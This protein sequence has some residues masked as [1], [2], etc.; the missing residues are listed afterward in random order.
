MESHVFMR[1]NSLKRSKITV[2]YHHNERIGGGYESSTH[3]DRSRTAL[4]YHIIKPHAGYAEEIEERIR[5]ANAVPKHNSI[6]LIEGLIVPTAEWISAL[7]PHEQREFFEY[8]MSFFTDWLGEGRFISSVVHMDETVPHMHF[9]F[10]PTTEDGRVSRNALLGNTRD[11]ISKLQDRFYE[12]IAEKYPEIDRGIP[13]RKTYRVHLPVHLLKSA[14]ELNTHYVDLYNAVQDINLI[15]SKEKKDY[16]MKLLSQYT[17]DYSTIMYYIKTAETY[18]GQV[19]NEAKQR[20]EQIGKY[21]EEIMG[22]DLEISRLK[23]DNEAL[24][25][26]RKELEKYIA[27]VPA[28][29]MDKI[30]ETEKKKK[31]RNRDI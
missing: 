27:E 18:L 31:E 29:V 11:D 23:E 9:V 13:K 16:V 10:V 26:S 28:D 1:L 15:N 4:N 22:K 30:R 14:A 5:Q 8:A 24:E 6:L 19:E 17:K 12:H 3:I 7:K 25:A 2:A 20:E 21:E